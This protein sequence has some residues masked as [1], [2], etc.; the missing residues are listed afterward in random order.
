[1]PEYHNRSWDASK[2]GNPTLNAE[3][4]VYYRTE[5]ARVNVELVRLDLDQEFR[6]PRQT[7]LWAFLL[8]AV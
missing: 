3:D 2:V 4:D 8:R 1:M 7:L 6:W 5:A